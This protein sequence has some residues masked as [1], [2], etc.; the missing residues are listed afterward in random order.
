MNALIAKAEIAREFFQRQCELDD[1]AYQLMILE[2]G[3]RFLEKVVQPGPYLTDANV[4]LY[5]E[6]LGACGFWDWYLYRFY[7]M[8]VEVATHWA[9]KDPVITIQSIEYKRDRFTQ[10]A[11]GISIYN[12]HLDSFDLWLKQLGERR[13]KITPVTNNTPEHAH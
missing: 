6:H 5:R 13:W 2:T 3:C 10:E 8:T 4:R 11:E 7:T 1:L 9:T 12:R